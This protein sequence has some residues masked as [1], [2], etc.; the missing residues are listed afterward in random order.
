MRFNQFGLT[1][2]YPDNWLVDTADSAGSHA[3]VTVYSPEGAF[4]SVSAHAPGGEAE[5]LA[6][7]VVAQM[8]TEYQDLD[9]AP[10]SD[11]VDGH[12][13][14]GFDLNFY[15]LDLTNTAAVRTLSTPSAIYL[16]FCQAEDREWD[17]ISHVFAAMT[18]SFV[19]A[20]DAAR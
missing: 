4:W 18:A 2:D 13:L 14:P 5:T 8:R 16:F 1:F 20:L 12:P 10:A 19:A 7:A 15:C 17:R 3:A 9:S 6:K 11:T